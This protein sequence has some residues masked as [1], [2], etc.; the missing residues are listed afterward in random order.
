MESML[1]NIEVPSL[2]LVEHRP[3]LASADMCRDTYGC[4]TW[5]VYDLPDDA[6]A[7]DIVKADAY[8]WHRASPYLQAFR[9]QKPFRSRTHGVSA[10]GA[11]V[12]WEELR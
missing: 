3:R 6:K 4:V 8:S 5:L 1:P 7:G 9:I 10:Y 11:P 2:A 12:G